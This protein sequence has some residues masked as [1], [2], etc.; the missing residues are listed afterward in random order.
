MKKLLLF[1]F[2]MPGIIASALGQNYQPVAQHSTVTF[3]V[4]HQMIFKSTVSGTFA[5]IKGVIQFDPKNLSAADFTVS[6]EAKTINSGIGMR[7]NDLR[8]EKYFD[9]EKYPT[10]IIKAKT[11]T[12]GTKDNDYLL[13]GTLTMKGKTLPVSF[14]FSAS[15]ENQGY[16]F[17]GHFQINRLAYDIGPDNSID[18][19]VEV[20]LVV[21]AK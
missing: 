15:P 19:T 21:E 14:A 5:G 10:I 17:K 6:V 9:V 4:S 12:K 2:G 8:E 1:I 7:D 11:I 18:K 16:L 13:S 3:K 20:D